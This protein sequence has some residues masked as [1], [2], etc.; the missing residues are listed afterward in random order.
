MQQ[1]D[2]GKYRD[3]GLAQDRYVPADELVKRL[4]VVQCIRE[5]ATISRADRRSPERGGILKRKRRLRKIADRYENCGLMYSK[6]VCP[7]CEQPYIGRRRCESRICESCAKKHAARIRRRQLGV[8]KSLKRQNGKRLMHLVLTKKSNP[9]RPNE[10]DDVRWLNKWTRKL[11]NELWSNKSGCGAFSVFEIGKHNNLHIHLLVYGYYIPQ[12]QISDLW[13]KLTGDSFVVH[14]QALH[15]PQQGVNYL[16]KYITKPYSNDDPKTKA[17][18]LNLIMG[19]RRI[20]TYGI[21]YN[22]KLSQEDAFACL[23]GNRKLSFCGFVPGPHVPF[24]ALFYAEAMEI[25]N[26]RKN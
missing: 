21:F 8:I 14:I 18:Y 10:T 25:I 3:A 13:R 23:C 11:V 19:I 16:L 6:A 22:I 17:S 15:N 4:A 5:T 7:K 1:M 24:G 12:Q 26:A 20:H 9:F 2:I